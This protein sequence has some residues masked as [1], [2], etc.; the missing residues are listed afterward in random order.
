MTDCEIV[1][2]SERTTWVILA[3]FM[4]ILTLSLVS[5]CS[6]SVQNSEKYNECVFDLR[7]DSSWHEVKA[8]SGVKFFTRDGM[9]VNVYEHE[10]YQSNKCPSKNQHRK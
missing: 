6:K 8:Y 4:V 2:K 1:K 9:S 5:A 3:V 10:N 7:S